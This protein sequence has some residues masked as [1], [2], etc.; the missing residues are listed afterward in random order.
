MKTS[1]LAASLLAAVA[2]TALA[3]AVQSAPL[4][5]V[6]ATVS[7]G[8]AVDFE[9][10]LPLRDSAGLEALL[11]AQQD[12]TSSS[13]HQWLT[14]AQFA[15][16]FGPQPADMASAAAAVKAAGLEVVEMHSRSMHVSGQ[17][18]QVNAFLHATLKTADFGAGRHDLVIEGKA[19]L[20][21]A[22]ASA[23]AYVVAFSG[24][25]PR[26]VN[27][28][29][30]GLAPDN[31][32]GAAGPY[33]YNDMKQAYDYPS[34]KTILPNGRRLDGAGVKV[35]I[36]METNALETD[37]Q[38]MF[39]HENFTVTTGKQPPSFKTLNIDGGAP[40]DPNS[41]GSFEASLDVQ[42]VLGG[43]P[44]AT[45]TLV[46]LPDLFDSHILDGYVTIVERNY[47]D[48][49]NSSFGG[50][51]LNYTAA[52]NGGV[53]YT[54][55]LKAFHEVFAQGNA[56]G[57]TFVAS[58]GDSAGLA[59]TTP[60][61]FNGKPSARF[62]ASVQTPADDP[63]VLSVGGTNLLTTPPNLPSL[64]SQYVGE[65]FDGDPEVPYDPYGVGINVPGGY[66]GA[67]GGR[68]VVFAA[69]FYQYTTVN[70]RSN[71]RTVPDV[72]MQVGGCPLGLAI[73]PCGPNRSAAIVNFGGFRYGVIG[74]SVSSPEFVGALALY[75]EYTGGGRLGNVN[76]FLYGQSASQN[77]LGGAGAPAGAQF[78]H[79]NIAGYDGHWRGY[80][81]QYNY[82]VGN[83]TPDVR[84]LFNM[85]ALAPAGDPR[86][87]SNP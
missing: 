36:V 21:P 26:Q 85:T 87:I 70:T 17:A 63:A 50:C 42:Q 74:T 44:G 15:Q 62:V 3:G 68:S 4:G 18:A 23:G 76:Y 75:Q 13:Y 82:A 8:T 59:C 24:M 83:G 25:P 45:V 32:N 47:W 53:D 52:Y 29:K 81:E 46:S 49:V 73:T 37:L 41:G 30:T 86:T 10:F 20:P 27:S 14:P 35:A 7:P 40:F 33:N 43:A 48:L 19:T 39:N 34:Y 79:K 56:Q 77:T 11:I 84:V 69:P 1:R 9:L 58:S 54:G 28:V 80:P 5:K 64:T 67:G 38:G 12:K 57:I 55:I 51:E 22:L 60:N 72:G 65:N 31:R 66:W 6:G 2:A 78:Y 16:R 61:Y 71:M